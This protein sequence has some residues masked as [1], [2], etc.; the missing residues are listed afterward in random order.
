MP[1]REVAGVVQ[2]SGDTSLSAC[3]VLDSID[4]GVAIVDVQTRVVEQVNTTAAVLF[5]ASADEIV[6]RRC[7]RFLCP[8]DEGKCPISDL[9]QD[10]DKSD[11]VLLTSDGRELPVMKSVKRVWIDGREKLLET[12]VDITRRLQVESALQESQERHRQL[13]EFALSG[14]AIHDI[15]LDS[16]GK[17]VDYIFLDANPAFETHAGLR[18][19]D[20]LGRRVT[21]VLPGIENTPFIDIYGKVVLTGE[22]VHFE[23]YAEPLKRYYNVNAYKIGK[24]SFA[25]VFTDITERKRAEGELR[26]S[27]ERY[28]VLFESSRDAIMVIAPPSWKFAAGNSATHKMFGVKDDNEFTRLGP[29]DLSPE[30]QPDGRL[31]AEKALDMIETALREGSVFFEWE[32]KRLTG[33]VFPATVLLTRMEQRGEVFIQATVRDITDNKRSQEA[34]L[35]KSEELERYFMSSLDLLCIAN[36]SGHFIRLNPEWERVLGYSLTE[37]KDRQFIDFVHPDDVENTLVALNQRGYGEEILSFENRYRCKDGSYRWIEWRSHRAGDLIHAIARD[38]TTRKYAEDA[39]RESEANFRTFFDTIDDVLVVATPNGHIQFA[40]K[41]FER[42]LGYGAEELMG[43]RLLDVFPRDRHEEAKRIFFEVLGGEPSNYA[44][45]LIAK[46]GAHIP[47]DARGWLGTWNGEACVFVT[48]KDL[49]AEQEAQQRFE[50]L[51]RNNPAIMALSTLS[52]GRFVDVNDAFLD[53]LGYQRGDVVGK[54]SDDIDLYPRAGQRLSIEENL[55]VTERVVNVEL[56]VKR[57]DGMVLDGLFSG[58]IIR[59]QDKK[60]YLTVII[61]ITSRKRAEAELQEANQ[62][63]EEAT[64]RANAMTARA[65]LAS[66]A[67]SEFLANMSHEI[68]TPMNGVIGMTGL[69][70]DTDLSDEQRRYAETVRSC[71]ES[72]LALINDILDFSKIEAGKLTLEILYFDLRALLDDFAGMMSLRAKEKHLDLTCVMSPNVPS[73]LRGDPG[74]LRQILV[75]LVGNAIKFTRNGEVAIQVKVER[76]S[77]S[78]ARLVFSVRDTGIGIPAD[79]INI[80]FNKFTQIDASTTRRYGG[81]GLGLAISKQLVELMGGAIGVE[82]EPGKGSEFWFTTRFEKQ[83]SIE[84]SQQH[85]FARIAGM[86]AMV[87]DDRPA[88]R[89]VLTSQLTAWGLRTAE[90]KDGPTAIRLLYEAL[91]ANDPFDFVFT[92]MQ[93]PGMDGEALGRIVTGEKRLEG[94]KLVMMTSLGQAGDVERLTKI[95]FS[96]CLLKPVRQSELFDCLVDLCSSNASVEAR[97]RL[98]ATQIPPRELPRTNIRVLLAEDNITNQQVAMAILRKLGLKADAVA[99]GREVIEALRTIPYDLVLMDIQMPEMDGLDATRIIR[100]TTDGTLNRNVPIIALTAHVMQGDREEC[101]AAGMNDY[102]AKPVTPHTLSNVLERWIIKL[103]AA[104][105]GDGTNPADRA[106]LARD[107]RSVNAIFDE[108]GLLARVMDDRDIAITV[109]SGFLDDIP[110]QIEAMRNHLDAKDV[111]SAERQ[112]HSIKGASAA[113]GGKRLSQLAFELEKAG[114]SA[115]LD[116]MKVLLPELMRVFDELKGAIK[117][118]ILFNT[119]KEQ[120]G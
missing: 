21:E 78:E 103:D 110:K 104:R 120:R 17:P 30:T 8:A 59:S 115:D 118:S 35:R 70:L 19:A 99:N 26:V 119:K 106:F 71:G 9:G 3:D 23:Q 12:F 39:L 10:V 101:V 53:V 43:M 46:T 92:D 105:R 15:V 88:N 107:E 47:I 52:D 50:R 84:V 85:V 79:K 48:G 73:L 4:A 113:V 94:T 114:K 41:S 66:A 87:V 51:F 77:E 86:R 98:V 22:P 69:L 72:L 58:E 32:H 67:K 28:R 14:I 5:G 81:T 20:V 25:T 62:Q 45:R 33:E 89:A 83:P 44:A 93:M 95:G 11:R 96:G 7:H 61:D 57:R 80:L 91:S 60:Y 36:T 24:K 108:E 56:Q 13:F 74:R 54:T 29:Y 112:A 49:S 100:A 1:N 65:E 38:V 40:N 76:E 18:V 55:Q 117:A 37:L 90:A 2:G 82:S 31:S 64:A 68:R 63:L 116:R 109:L 27:E 34:L 97:K 16:A 42:K 75:N 111:K 102:V 6:G